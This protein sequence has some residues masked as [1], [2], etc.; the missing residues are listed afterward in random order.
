ME[1]IYRK[2]IQEIFPLQRIKSSLQGIWHGSHIYVSSYLS[3]IGYIIS[4]GIKIIML[5][6]HLQKFISGLH[7]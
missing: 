7:A 1:D 6:A 5:I 3:L 4:P 2:Y